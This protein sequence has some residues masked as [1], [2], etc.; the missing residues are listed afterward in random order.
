M[1]VHFVV[2]VCWVIG[3]VQIREPFFVVIWYDEFNANLIF[4]LLTVRGMTAYY[5]YNAL[6]VLVFL[7]AASLEICAVIWLEPIWY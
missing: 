5:L 3:H 4:T 1:P 2:A 6:I 7:I